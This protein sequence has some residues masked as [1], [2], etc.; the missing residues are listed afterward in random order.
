[1]TFCNE[2]QLPIG[3]YRITCDNNKIYQLG[4]VKDDCPTDPRV[5]EDNLGTIL[6]FADF[7]C[8]GD[9]N[10]GEDA[11][12]QIAALCR[13]YGKSDEDI[14]E[15]TVFEEMNFIAEHE[16]ILVLPL[17]LYGHSGLSIAIYKQDVW[18]GKYTGF[19]YVEK[20]LFLSACP[21]KDTEHWKDYAKK[22][23]LAEVEVYDRYLRGEVYMWT[24]QDCIKVTRQD[25]DGNILSVTLEPEDEMGFHYIFGDYYSLPTV[26]DILEQFGEFKE[27][28]RIE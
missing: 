14:N 17:Y 21:I 5:Y 16:D 18:D 4:V 13:K 15:L 28:Q 27:L 1:M 8:Y 11:E 6:C 7:R 26:Q 12:N 10:S 25:L 23:L 24:I 19:I 9:C 2:T 20:E 22:T 3:Q